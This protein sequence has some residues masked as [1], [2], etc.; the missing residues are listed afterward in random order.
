LK[1]FAGALAGVVLAGCGSTESPEQQQQSPRDTAVS[2]KALAARGPQRIPGRY[3]VVMK[4]PGPSERSRAPDVRQEA[5]DIARRHGA[6]VG[7]VYRHAL[8]GFVAELEDARVEALR[9]DERVAFVEQDALAEGQEAQF[10]PPW[11]LDK[12]DGTDGFYRYEQTGAGVNVYV[13]DSGIR[14][15][16]SEF[17]GRMGAG[18]G[19]IN[20]GHGTNDCHGHGTHVAGTI[21]GSTYGV[22]KAVTLHPVRVLDCNNSGPWSAIIAGIDWVTAN[23][24]KPAV[25]NMSI[26]G[27]VSEAVDQAV[28]RSLA[29]GVL[30]VISAGNSGGNACSYTPARVAE[31]L[32]IGAMAENNQRASFSN[33]GDC[34]DF[35]APGQGIASASHVADDGV[36]LMNGTSMA[37]PHVTGVAARYLQ[38]NP[39]ASPDTLAAVLAGHSAPQTVFD[40]NRSGGYAW[41]DRRVSSVFLDHGMSTDFTP[42]QV[43][44]LAPLDGA[45][46]RGTVRVTASASDTTAVSRVEFWVGN[47]LRHTDTSAPYEFTWNTPLDVNG[48]TALTAKAFDT[49]FNA[50]SA[51]V[52]VTVQ[53]SGLA[54]VDAARKVPSCLTPGARCDS[55]AL[56]VGRGPL[57][58]EANAPN[59][60]LAACADGTGGVF[61]VDESLDRLRV[62]TMDGGP[63]APGKAVTIEATVWAYSEYWYDQLDLF[64]APNADSPVW[65]HLVTLRPTQPGS[66]V[67]STTLTLPSGRLQAI[68]GSFRFHREGGVADACGTLAYDDRDDLV[69][70]VDAPPQVA[71]TSPASGAVLAGTVSLTAT[72]SDAEG[73]A[74][75]EFYDGATLLGSDT[76]APYALDW[77]TLG[78]ANGS[79]T[80]TVRAH[81]D[82]GN[83]AEQHVQVTVDNDH[84]PTV[85]VTS[86][87]PG[88]VVGGTVVFSADAFDDRAVDRVLFYV[89]SKYITYDAKA[90]YSI[91]FNSLN[92]ANGSYVLTTKAYDVA[93]NVTVSAGVPITIQN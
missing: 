3:I 81:D 21:G 23:H 80:L 31:A 61:R 7:H 46:L 39:A 38:L 27:N 4:E 67:L 59:T 49:A 54:S 53:N 91:N 62:S 72:A 50:A 16:H 10:Q 41:P 36:T 40:M 87:A 73:L 33:D 55:D 75:V 79:H 12:L 84:P 89:G 32:T 34:V 48:P 77:N 42:P 2:S 83:T 6:K 66:Q 56:L 45:T 64:H 71:L 30:Y 11:G 74:R 69:F 76:S 43:Q 63:L 82:S 65:T 5:E 35:F 52:A 26:G 8:R 86:P 29:A 44:L 1:S 90:P 24:V 14:A 57:G 92:F 88:A 25:A 22:A 9:R 70:L 28:R 51:K 37:A 17:Q 19:F 93:G 20:D 13:L 60:L 18:A 47:T 78:A 58:P 15:T 68:R 85:R